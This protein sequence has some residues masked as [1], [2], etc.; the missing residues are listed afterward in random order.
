MRHAGCRRGGW[1]KVVCGALLILLIVGDFDGMG[2]VLAGPSGN[3]WLYAVLTWHCLPL[4]GCHTTYIQCQSCTAAGLVWCLAG[5]ARQVLKRCVLFCVGE[6]GLLLFAAADIAFRGF[7]VCRKPAHK[8]HN[9]RSCFAASLQRTAAGVAGAVL[10]CVPTHNTRRLC[11]RLLSVQAL[12][13][14]RWLQPFVVRRRL[15]NVLG[16][17]LL[18]IALSMPMV[19]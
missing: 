13:S 10:P 1:N 7:F 5:P 6:G 8:T 19:D 4:Q 16:G 17:R 2:G 11:Q 3:R 15:L 12:R 9:Q 18:A 14:E